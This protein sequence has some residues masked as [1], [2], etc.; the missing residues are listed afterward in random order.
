MSIDCKVLC[1]CGG[2][3]ALIRDCDKNHTPAQS[4]LTAAGY[5]VMI[6]ECLEHT[7]VVPCFG[8][9]DCSFAQH[10]KTYQGR[11]N[12]F[13]EQPADCFIGRHMAVRERSALY[14]STTDQEEIESGSGEVEW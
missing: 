1:R 14:A 7:P 6:G 4:V 5:T 13:G 3:V 8:R 12:L 11:V 10:F 2:Q 9:E